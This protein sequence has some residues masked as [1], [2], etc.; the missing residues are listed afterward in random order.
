MIVQR[1]F[2]SK[3]DK[4]KEDNKKKYSAFSNKLR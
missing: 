2:S 4:E 1:I 3:S